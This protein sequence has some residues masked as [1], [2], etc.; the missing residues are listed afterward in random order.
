M[1][2]LMLAPQPF[3]QARGTPISVYQRLKGLSH[4]GHSVDLLTYHLGED[5]SLPGVTIHRIPR[6]PFIDRVVIGPSWPKAVLDLMMI[7]KAIAMLAKTRYDVIH[8]HEEAA[9]FSAILAR[10]FRSRHL[11]DMHSSLPRQLTA[12]GFAD[13]RLTIGMFKCFEKWT[14]DHSDAVITIDPELENHVRELNPQTKLMMIENLPVKYLDGFSSGQTV[15]NVRARLGLQDKLVVVY[16]GNLS[17]NQGLNLLLKSARAVTEEHPDVSFV[18]VGGNPEQVDGCRMQAVRLGVERHVIFV[19]SV[20]MGDV[21]VFEELADILVSPRCEGTSVP[22]KIYSYLHSGKPIIATRLQAH[23][24]VLNDDIAVLVEPTASG[25]S[26]GISRLAA[27]AV[28][29][30]E[31]GHRAQEFARRLYNFETYC[32]KLSGVYGALLPG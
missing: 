27:D 9:F 6:I 22:L 30:K 16:T 4:H 31:L 21:T 18:I 14:V 1:N 2:V 26:G 29:R 23:T 11:Y 15:D 12:Y 13:N 10:V 25:L 28:L 19:G 20:P 24:M 5:I 8:A 17:Q 3:F 7:C 32:E